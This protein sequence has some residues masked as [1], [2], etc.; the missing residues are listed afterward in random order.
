[1]RGTSCQASQLAALRR[2][3]R[4]GARPASGLRR[5]ACGRGQSTRRPLPSATRP[6]SRRRAVLSVLA[7][8]PLT[9]QCLPQ[10]GVDLLRR[11]LLYAGRHAAVYVQRDADVGVTEA[12]LDD[13][14]ALALAEQP[15]GMGASKV[16]R[17]FERARF[18]GKRSANERSDTPRSPLSLAGTPPATSRPGTHSAALAGVCQHVSCCVCTAEVRG[19]TPLRSTSDLQV[20]RARQAPRETS[21]EP[22]DNPVTMNV[23]LRY[24]LS[25]LAPADA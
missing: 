1:M 10:S 4:A 7:I 9:R 18:F 21:R 11:L 6:A 24:I 5:D 22:A 14:G 17:R 13:P 19:S 8:L 25:T 2:R 3:R 15:A 23:R 12:S 20:D 16:A